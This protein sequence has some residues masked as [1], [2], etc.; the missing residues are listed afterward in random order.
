MCSSSAILRSVGVR[1]RGNGFCALLNPSNYKG[2][3]VL[4]LVT[5]FTSTARNIVGVGNRAMG[6]VPTGQHGIGAIF[7]SCTLFPRVGMF[8]GVTFKL[9]VGGVPGSR[10]VRGI[11]RTLGVIRLRNCRG[12]RVDRVSNNRRRQITVT[13][14]VIGRPSIL[15]LSRPL[16]TLSLGLHASVRCRLERLRR[17]LNVAFVFIARSRRRTLTVDS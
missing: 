12:H 4:H 11:G 6:S 17:H 5:K 3:A 10:V 8:S 7:R 1:L 2:A 9:A 16:S 14:T 15:L 13:E